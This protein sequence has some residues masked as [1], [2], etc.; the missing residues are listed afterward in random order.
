MLAL[1]IELC[2]SHARLEVKRLHLKADA[3]PGLEHPLEF[4]AERNSRFSRNTHF[5][6]NTD[7]LMS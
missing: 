2:D 4:E 5:S 6:R 7:S 1:C 3:S